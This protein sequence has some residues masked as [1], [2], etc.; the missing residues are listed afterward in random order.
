MSNPQGD[1]RSRKRV[2]TLLPGVGGAGQSATGTSSAGSGDLA[3]CD[4]HH[5]A[6]ILFGTVTGGVVTIRARPVNVPTGDSNFGAAKATLIGLESVNLGKEIV[7]SWIVDGF[8][9]AFE[10]TVNTAITGGGKIA[11]IVNSVPTA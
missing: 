10:L 1:T 3:F 6:I 11:A 4:R 9:E 5:I 2:T 7:N 8:F